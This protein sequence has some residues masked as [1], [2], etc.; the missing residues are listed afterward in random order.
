MNWF[1]KLFTKNVAVTGVTSAAIGGAI[2]GVA[3]SLDNGQFNG[4]Q[5]STV[6]AT[7]AIIGV[8]NYLRKS[9][10][11]TKVSNRDQHADQR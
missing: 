4:K 10:D 9:P 1:K 2:D 6:A 3:Q 7:A 8:L 11:E 5:I